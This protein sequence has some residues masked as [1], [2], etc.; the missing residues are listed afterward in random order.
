MKIPELPVEP[1]AVDDRRYTEAPEDE[2]LIHELVKIADRKT[3]PQFI[4][5]SA[6][7]MPGGD[8]DG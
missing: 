2:D 3:K 5:P 7:L 6:E 4:G 1:V 8:G